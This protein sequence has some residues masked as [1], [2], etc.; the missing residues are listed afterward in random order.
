MKRLKRVEEIFKKVIQANPDLVTNEEWQLVH[1]HDLPCSVSKQDMQKLLWK[2]GNPAD[3]KL[4]F[5]HNLL[6]FSG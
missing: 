2:F 6:H 5:Q 1:F 4:V 3:I